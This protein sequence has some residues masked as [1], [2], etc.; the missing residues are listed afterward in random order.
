M[1]DTFIRIFS[2]RKYF[3]FTILNIILFSLLFGETII[4]K[5]HVYDKVSGKPIQGANIIVGNN[6]TYSDE[7]GS[8]KI[9]TDTPRDIQVVVIGYKTEKL[10]FTENE[11]NIYL[12]REALQ[13][14]PI[15]VTAN[16]IITGITPVAYSN[17]N[18]EEINNQYVVEDV[19]MILSTEAGIH[20]Y[21]ESGNGTGYS[22]VSIRGFDQSRISV[23]LD[24][25]PLN[26]NESHQVYWV[27]HGD[28]LA[29]ADNV[30]IQRGIG[31]SLYGSSA[32]GGSINVQTKISSPIEKLTFTGSVGSYNTRKGSIKYYSGERFKS[33]SLT[34]RLSS[35]NSDGYRDDSE[36]EQTAFSFGLE[37][38]KANLNNQFRVLIGKEISVLQWDG[39]SQEMLNDRS[40]RTGKMDWTI[41]FTDDFLQQIYSLNTRYVLSQKVILRNVAYL[42][43][44]SGFYEVEKFGQDYYSYN[45][46]VGNEYTDEEEQDLTVDFTRRKWIQNNYYGIVP[47]LT[48]NPGNLRLDV[49]FESRVYSGDH[50]GEVFHVFDPVLRAKLPNKYRYYEYT[51]NKFT[52]SA[53]GHLL[54][55]FPFGLHLVGDIQL[56]KHDWELD[57]KKI[58]HAAGHNLKADWEFI[59]PRFGFTYELNDNIAFFG[60]YGIAQKEPSDAQII[61]ADDVWSEPKEAAAEKI[62][63]TEFGLNISLNALY[64]KLNGYRI[65]YFNEILSDIYDFAEGEFDVESADKTRHE[66]IEIEGGVKVTDNLSVRVNGAWSRNKFISGEYDGKTLTNVP[67]KLANI[68][69]DYESNK[70]YGIF[71]YGKY[72]GKQFIDKN[73]TSDLVIDPYFLVNLNGWIK[74]NQVK[75]TARINNLFDTLY[76]TY[77]YEYYGGYYWPGATRNYN[78]SLQLDIK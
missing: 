34:A 58:G 50:F 27:D 5:G 62:K 69:V 29:D 78:I 19:P 4:I 51:G 63:D 17:L 31:N 56:Q 75:I 37:H 44:G 32:F 68:T 74:F 47:T 52:L 67:N 18:V 60:N 39:I 73:N 70:N 38:N 2:F 28:I 64:L 46:D 54:Y 11:L 33:L 25:I 66:G 24:N 65:D 22:Y 53:F 71:V 45:L 23:M 6:G 16:K 12:E 8:F 30:E 7:F 26:D 3:R 14:A 21:S 59:N 10:D 35:I 72:V 15:E 49:G 61:E 9:L 42:V 57:Q 20:A 36:S 48:Y 77:G 40:L 55:S 1:L 76:A 41:P 13:S 43:K